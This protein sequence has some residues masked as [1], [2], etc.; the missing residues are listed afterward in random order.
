[1]KMLVYNDFEKMYGKQCTLHAEF[2]W[3]GIL[4]ES[5]VSIS[6][7]ERIVHRAYE[8]AKQI[9]SPFSVD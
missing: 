3:I 5:C 2:T 8:K 4:A 6:V 7:N 1:M 9:S